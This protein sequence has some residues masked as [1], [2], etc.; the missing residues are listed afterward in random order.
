MY[1]SR[2][3]QKCKYR[4]T[5]IELLEIIGISNIL[6]TFIALYVCICDF[7]GVLACVRRFR[8][9]SRDIELK[10]KQQRCK[11]TER[12]TSI[13]VDS[14]FNFA[15]SIITLPVR[16]QKKNWNSNDA[17]EIF[18]ICRPAM[19]NKPCMQLPTS[20]SLLAY[21]HFNKT[22]ERLLYAAHADIQKHAV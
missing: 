15:V 2:L 12:P 21:S 11:H 1:E 6:Q 9:P 18:Q 17:R 14:D 13:D 8:P 5:L 19:L 16:Q 4:G 22:G 20:Y 10:S 3:R 7:D